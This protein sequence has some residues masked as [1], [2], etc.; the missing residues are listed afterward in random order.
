VIIAGAGRRQRE[1]TA[2]LAR[3]KTAQAHRLAERGASD[4]GSVRFATGFGLGFPLGGFV[5]G[6]VVVPPRPGLLFVVIPLAGLLR[7]LFLKAWRSRLEF[8][9]GDHESLSHIGFVRGDRASQSQRELP[10]REAIPPANIGVDLAI[11]LVNRS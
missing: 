5:I 11:G 9:L 10:G 6:G 4:P 3:V 1:G 7:Q 8:E 2:V